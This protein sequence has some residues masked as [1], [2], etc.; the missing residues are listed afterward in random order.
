V[1]GVLLPVLRFCVSAL[2]VKNKSVQTVQTVHAQ[3]P[4]C[5]SLILVVHGFCLG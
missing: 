4:G 3:P 5:S 1:V 2:G